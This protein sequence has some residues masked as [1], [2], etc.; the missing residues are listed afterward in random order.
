MTR[1]L[2]TI[3]RTSGYALISIEVSFS[4]LSRP[5]VTQPSLSPSELKSCLTEHLANELHWVL[6]AAS[7]WHVQ[8]VL[9]LEIVG[10]EVQV[11]AMDSCFLHARSLFEF[12]TAKSTRNHYGYDTFGLSPFKSTYSASWVDPLH[13]Y[14][15]HIR[16]RSSPQQLIGLDGT[17][18]HL[19]EMPVDFAR[20]IVRL[21]RDFPTALSSHKNP[22][23]VALATDARIALRTAIDAAEKVQSSDVAKKC[24]AMVNKSIPSIS[25]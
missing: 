19:N 23:V 7:E 4:L 11:F 1:E 5:M 17:R 8:D 14:L 18:K 3:L 15:M 24:E 6:R 2:K 10:Y 25:W 13:A 9:H 22:A 20:E 16:D 21:W 12:F